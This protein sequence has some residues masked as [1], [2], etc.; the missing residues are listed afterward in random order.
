[1]PIFNSSRGIPNLNVV[2]KTGNYSVQLSDNYLTGDCTGGQFAFTL[3]SAVGI[4][5]Q[6]FTFH[7]VN[8]TLGSYIE[9]LTTGSQTINGVVGTGLNVTLATQDEELTVISDGA[10]W[11]A[12]RYIPTQWIS[13]TPTG[14][15]TTNTTYTGDF[16]RLGDSLEMRVTLVFSGTPNTISAL[17][18]NIPTGLN[19]DTTKMG[20]AA[21]TVSRVLGSNGAIQIPG[22]NNYSVQVFYN[23]VSAVGINCLKADGSA[24]TAISNSYAVTQAVPITLGNTYSIYFTCFFPVVNWN[25]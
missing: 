12:R 6:S 14:T 7:R 4:A 5:G 18:V 19:I 10:N 3:P 16:R 13:F 15:F 25:A 8:Q 22:A 2:A 23:S 20:L 11:R 17:L 9:I 1:M 24:G 21:S